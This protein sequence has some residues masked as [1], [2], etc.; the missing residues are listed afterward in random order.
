[1]QY[2]LVIIGGGAGALARYVSSLFV[3]LLS[4]GGF[5]LGTLF[6][7][8]AGAAAIGFL[9]ALFDMFSGLS[10]W[11]LLLITGFLGGYTTFSTYA[12]ETARYFLDGN[13]K[14]ALINIALHN[15]LCVLLVLGGMG[16]GK[17]L[18]AK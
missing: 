3:D 13:I 17:A 18:F 15:G 1:M 8:G 9:A 4:N 5:P 11:R 7:N 10:R 12:L 2:L 16:L 14:R 6:V